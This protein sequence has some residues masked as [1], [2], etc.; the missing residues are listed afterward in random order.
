MA[1]SSMESAA[2]DGGRGLERS[3]R[4]RPCIDLHEGKVRENGHDAP[5]CN[6]ARAPPTSLTSAACYVKRYLRL[7][8]NADGIPTV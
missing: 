5:V 7:L 6:T 1:E 4:F 2:G 3:V 8:D